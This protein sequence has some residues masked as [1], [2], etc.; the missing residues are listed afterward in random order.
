MDNLSEF[1]LVTANGR[2]LRWPVKD[3]RLSGIQA[4]NCGQ[5]DSVIGAALVQPEDE[6]MLLTVD[7]YGR[8]LLAEWIPVPPGPNRT[9]KSLL[10]RRSSLAAIFPDPAWLL[11]N[12]NLLE[13]NS[14]AYP[15]ENSTR[16]QHLLKLEPQEIIAGSFSTSSIHI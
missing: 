13:I 7:G 14:S 5:E 12:K 1:V 6:L 3:L 10:A 8:R 4:L 15:L 11:T 9:G 2:G 16:S